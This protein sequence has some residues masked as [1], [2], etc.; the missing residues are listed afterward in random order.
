MGQWTMTDIDRVWQFWLEPKPQTAEAIAAKNALWFSGGPELDRQIRV[1]FGHLVEQARAGELASWAATTRGRIALIV[2]I[3]QFSRNVYRG[4]HQAYS[5]DQRA[6][7]LAV[8]GYDSGAFAHLDAIEQMFTYL[9]FT[10]SENIAMQKR[11]VELAQRA[12]LGAPEAWRSM[13]F[14]AVDYARKHLDVIARF[15]RFPHRNI[16]LN[17]TNTSEESA[18]LDYLRVA[19]QWL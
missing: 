5:C 11:A 10:H 18:Y 7:A 6:L 9:P 16:V 14:G 19:E 1:Q 2:L 17:R 8:E 4:T 3:D 15:G 13:M 12:A